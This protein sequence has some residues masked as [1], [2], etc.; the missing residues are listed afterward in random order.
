[1]IFGKLDQNLKLRFSGCWDHKITFNFNELEDTKTHI[2]T[3]ERNNSQSRWL[4]FW[5]F[6]VDW[7]FC[8]YS[9]NFKQLGCYCS[10]LVHFSSLFLSTSSSRRH[11]AASLKNLC[12][13]RTFLP[14]HQSSS[15]YGHFESYSRTRFFFHFATV[16]HL[17]SP[18]TEIG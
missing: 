4:I 8:S 7:N 3:Q 18:D 5:K 11:I 13:N 14:T 16:P 6:I 9:L 10:L 1:M 2:L 15:D 17:V 12:L